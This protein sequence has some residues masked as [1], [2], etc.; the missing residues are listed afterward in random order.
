LPAL[1]YLIKILVD[2]VLGL[3]LPADEDAVVAVQTLR[4]LA[5]GFIVTSLLWAAALATILDGRLRVAAAYF[6]IAGVCAFFGVIHSPL[7]TEQIGLPHHVLR[8]LDEVAPQFSGAARYQTPYHWAGAYAL[9]ALML[10]GLSFAPA[11]DSSESG[12]RSPELTESPPNAEPKT[13]D[14]G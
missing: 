4:C 5:N 2:K 3:R 13:P 6:L 14:A 11:P 12:V 8:H 7:Q 10:L 9:L 1:A